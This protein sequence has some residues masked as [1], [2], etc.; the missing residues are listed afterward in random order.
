MVMWS[1]LSSDGI[2]EGNQEKWSGY[3]TDRCH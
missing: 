3:C 2:K 1:E